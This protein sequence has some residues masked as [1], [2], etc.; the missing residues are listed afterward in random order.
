MRGALGSAVVG[1]LVVGVLVVAAGCENTPPTL[2]DDIDPEPPDAGVA[3]RGALDAGSLAALP[4]AASANQ[5]FETLLA[6]TATE[7]CAKATVQFAEGDSYFLAVDTVTCV[8]NALATRAPGR[9][10]YLTQ[11]V[12]G[13]GGVNTEHVLIIGGD[14]S[15]VYG[16]KA[17]LYV[18][19]LTEAQ[20]HPGSDP[21]QLCRLKPPSF[22]EACV[23]QLAP[24]PDTAVGT[25]CAFGDGGSF[26]ASRL[27]WFEACEEQSPA[28]CE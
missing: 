19:G 18:E 8:M 17:D 13:N 12:Y 21:S 2:A 4:D 22:F 27:P 14:G 11:S 1:V 7:P 24:Q 28:S 25:D 26:L 20:S 6:C 5:D 16:R 10:R 3:D 9:Y 23:S 15:V